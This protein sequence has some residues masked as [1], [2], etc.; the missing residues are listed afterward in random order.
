MN[1]KVSLILPLGNDLSTRVF[2]GL[3]C[4]QTLLVPKMIPDFDKVIPPS[5]QSDLGI[6]RLETCEV[7]EIKQAHREAVASFDRSGVEG[8]TKRHHFVLEHHM[9]GNRIRAMVNQ[10]LDVASGKNLI[11]FDK[12][13]GI[14]YSLGLTLPPSQR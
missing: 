3:L 14:S 2:D 11:S 5:A 10:I 6:I 9:L 8:M 1:Y 12:H 4:G 7:S 13:D